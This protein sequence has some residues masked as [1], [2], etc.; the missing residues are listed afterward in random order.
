MMMNSIHTGM[1]I[2]FIQAETTYNTEE[3]IVLLQNRYSI[4]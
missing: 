3:G 4:S 1:T 2:V